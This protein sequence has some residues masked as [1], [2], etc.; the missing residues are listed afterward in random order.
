MVQ[1]K[2]D[3]PIAIAAFILDTNLFYGF[4]FTGMLFRLTLMLQVIVITA[5]G[6]FSCFQEFFQ[7]VFSP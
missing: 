1:F 7:R 6:E 4:L 2:C 5:P 3:P